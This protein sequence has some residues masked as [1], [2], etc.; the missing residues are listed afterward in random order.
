[1]ENVARV[2]GDHSERPTVRRVTSEPG[3]DASPWGVVQPGAMPPMMLQLW[4][5]DGRMLSFPYT[6]ICELHCRDAGRI[7]LY[8]QSMARQ[9]IT[10]EGRRLRDLAKRLSQAAVVWVQQ[11]D[12]RQPAAPESLPEIVS[13]TIERLAE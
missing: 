4:L 10:I 3:N 13:I 6:S 5:A 7:E 8:V 1:M 12:P 9:V 11:R 2:F